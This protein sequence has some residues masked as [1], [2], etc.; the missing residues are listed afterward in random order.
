MTKINGKESGEI[1]SNTIAYENIN[2][3]NLSGKPFVN[4]LKVS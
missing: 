4:I 3:F 1:F 2:G